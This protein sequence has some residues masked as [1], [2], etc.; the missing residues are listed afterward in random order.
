MD[1]GMPS[2]VK[3]SFKLF[4]LIGQPVIYLVL[5]FDKNSKKGTLIVL[6][7]LLITMLGKSTQTGLF[8]TTTLI[9]F[10]LRQMGNK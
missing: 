3:L 7:N 5:D 6:V 8:T 10:L 1:M 4:Q 2:A 9:P